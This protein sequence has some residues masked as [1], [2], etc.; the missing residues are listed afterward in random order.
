[1]SKGEFVFHAALLLTLSAG[2]FWPGVG[3][4]A[5]LKAKFPQFYAGLEAHEATFGERFTAKAKA[6]WLEISSGTVL[7]VVTLT[8][9]GTLTNL[10]QIDF[11]AFDLTPDT[12]KKITQGLL[13]ALNLVKAVA[14]AKAKVQ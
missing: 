13:V 4:R 10:M 9:P 14:A 5:R 6:L 2:Y 12:V 3:A 1:M 11:G 7:A 8:D